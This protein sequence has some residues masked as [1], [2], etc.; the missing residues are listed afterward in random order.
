MTAPPHTLCEARHV[1]IAGVEI[2]SVT[3]EGVVDLA[4]RA[5]ALGKGCRVVTANT[6]ILR[7]A[8]RDP[9]ARALVDRATAVVADGMPLVWASRILGDPLPERVTGSSLIFSLSE[10][11]AAEG[12]SVFVLG[13]AP[14]VPELAADRLRERY[15]ALRV[16]GAESPAFG[17]DGDPAAV[18][19]V[20]RGVREAAPDLV[21]VGMGFPRQEVLIEALVEA[22]PRAFYIGCGAAIPMAA[23]VVDRAPAVLQQSGLEWAYRLLREPGRLSRRYLRND[24]VFALGL[25]ATTSV[26]RARAQGEGRG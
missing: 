25:L 12:R 16:V 18:A 21:F 8:A 26:Q 2:C 11:A 22:H 20:V 9:V 15:P 4:R 5:W 17:F 24:L 23:G 10:L 3:E 14:G 1:R 13:G 19:D 7:L 6:D